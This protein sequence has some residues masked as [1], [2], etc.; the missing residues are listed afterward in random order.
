MGSSQFPTKV[1]NTVDVGTGLDNLDVWGTNHRLCDLGPD[2]ESLEVIWSSPSL[3]MW[4]SR[5]EQTSPRQYYDFLGQRGRGLRFPVMPLSFWKLLPKLP[6]VTGIWRSYLHHF[7]KLGNEIEYNP[8]LHSNPQF[9]RKQITWLTCREK[10]AH[11]L[12]VD[13]EVNF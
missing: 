7:L 6:Q 4:D 10:L 1:F 2:E 3:L 9:Q 5:D 13:F 12:F 8:C 11:F